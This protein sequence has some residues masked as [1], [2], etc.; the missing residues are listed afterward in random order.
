MPLTVLL[1]GGRAVVRRF[2]CLL[3]LLA[4]I[5]PA[6][7]AAPRRIGNFS[8][9]MDALTKG[10]PVSV[11]VDY[12]RCR[13]VEGGDPQ[14]APAHNGGF[15]VVSWESRVGGDLG[16]ERV[17]LLLADTQVV[18]RGRGRVLL[19]HVELAV[20]HDDQV[21]IAIRHLD[22]GS[23]EV[24]STWKLATVFDRGDAGAAAFYRLD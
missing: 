4:I 21:Q 2:L 15:D 14:F 10:A 1:P 17:T 3:L 13:L 9:L 22:P 23:Y 11:V 6:A 12:A 16:S 8:S 20:Q 5:L 18:S 7:A 24:V 19:R